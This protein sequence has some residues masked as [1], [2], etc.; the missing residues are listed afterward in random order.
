MVLRFSK[1]LIEVKLLLFSISNTQAIVSKLFSELRFSKLEL[2]LIRR[3]STLV[4]FSKPL[5][6]VSKGFST[7]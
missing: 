4:M 5:K 1:P 3:L 6:L 2:L 7:I